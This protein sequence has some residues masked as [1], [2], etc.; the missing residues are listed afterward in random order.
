[1][2]RDILHDFAAFC[3]LNAFLTVLL[4][5]LALLTGAA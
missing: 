2:L 1:M 5:G 3:S 4:L